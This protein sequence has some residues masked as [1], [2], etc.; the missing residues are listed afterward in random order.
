MPACKHSSS[1]MF[2][3]RLSNTTAYCVPFFITL[4]ILSGFY[5]LVRRFRQISNPDPAVVASTIPSHASAKEMDVL[6]LRV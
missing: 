1:C 6:I 3:Y 5:F 4:I 2:P